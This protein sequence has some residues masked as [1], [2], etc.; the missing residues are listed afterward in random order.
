M[1]HARTPGVMRTRTVVVI[2]VAL[3]ATLLAA[4]GGDDVG[5]VEDRVAALASEVDGVEDDLRTVAVDL[6]ALVPEATDRFIEVTAFEIKGTTSRTSLDPPSVDP[7]TLSDGYG[8]NAP[9]F[10]EGNPDNWRVASYLWNP[11]Q[12]VAY[13]GDTLNL[14]FFILNG[15]EHVVWVEDP[16]GNV[17]A[18][19]TEMNRG[20]EYDFVVN[21]VKPGV[22]Q[23]ICSTHGPTMTAEILV[24]PRT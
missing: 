9:G 4:C 10:D 21:A 13:Q 12:L 18:D 20:R 23:L 3:A 7:S 8:Y 17:V 11:G 24:L 15:N 16:D 1:S 14:H 6:E 2:A 5:P 22:Y 19:V